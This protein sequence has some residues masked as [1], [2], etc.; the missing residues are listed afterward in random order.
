MQIDSEKLNVEKVAIIFSGIVAVLIKIKSFIAWC[1]DKWAKLSPMVEPIIKRVELAAAD[2]II[3]LEE[4]KKIAMDTIADAEKQGL[5]KLNWLN[6]WVIGIIVDRVAS[7]LPDIKVSKAAAQLV[8]DA[9]AR[10]KN[11]LAK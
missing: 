6:R 1:V 7:K 4:R 10:S 9:I 2:N 8:S 3:T 5:I 11:E